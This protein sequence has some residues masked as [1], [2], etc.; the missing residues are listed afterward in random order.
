MNAMRCL[1]RG[2]SSEQRSMPRAA[3]II[4]A[5]LWAIIN[6]GQARALPPLLDELAKRGDELGCN[7]A[8]YTLARGEV[9]RLLRESDQARESYD[10]AYT[11]AAPLY[12]MSIMR[13]L[14]A[15]GMP[16]HGR[17][18]A[19]GCTREKPLNGWTVD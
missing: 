15:M 6:Q 3:A 10:R 14:A 9:Y 8:G 11:L 1:R 7:G 2:I 16:G 12:G 18:A 5:D 13:E 17:I 19:R 4:T